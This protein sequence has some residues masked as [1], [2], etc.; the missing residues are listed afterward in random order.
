[1]THCTRE[2]KQNKI[3]D[4]NIYLLFLGRKVK[5]LNIW[6]TSEMSPHLVFYCF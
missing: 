4:E 5:G 6:S 1:M 2:K 3:N